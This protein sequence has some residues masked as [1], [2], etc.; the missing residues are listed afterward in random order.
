MKTALRGLGSKTEFVVLKSY[1]GGRH[2]ERER[3]CPDFS[4]AAGAAQTLRTHNPA[5]RF[6]VDVAAVS[7]RLRRAAARAARR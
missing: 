3:G 7:F 6:R 2:W 5:V 4:T 1:D